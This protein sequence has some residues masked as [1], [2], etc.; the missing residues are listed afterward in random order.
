MPT[1]ADSRFL[2]HGLSFRFRLGVALTTPFLGLLLTHSH[3]H[4]PGAMS[5]RADAD[6]EIESVGRGLL[7]DLFKLPFDF[8]TLTCFLR[9]E[10]IDRKQQATQSIS[11]KVFNGAENFHTEVFHIAQDEVPILKI[12]KE[13][14]PDDFVLL[15]SEVEVGVD[16]LSGQQI[17]DEIGLCLRFCHVRCRARGRIWHSF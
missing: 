15:G 3:R 14:I 13:V 2:A 4:E 9:H 11:S 5:F 17:E 10:D 6:R 16:R 1:I 7:E 8:F 12:G